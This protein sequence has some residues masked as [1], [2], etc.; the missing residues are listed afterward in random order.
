VAILLPIY[1]RWFDLQWYAATFVSLS[2]IP[3][4]GTALW[5]WIGR[6]ETGRMQP[7]QN[8]G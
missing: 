6:A 2:L 8:G 1:G 3:I 7:A 4:L 5:W